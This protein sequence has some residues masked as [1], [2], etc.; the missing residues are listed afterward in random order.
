VQI[1]GETLSITHACSSGEVLHHRTKRKEPAGLPAAL[2]CWPSN[3]RAGSLRAGT[4]P[5]YTLPDNGK[6]V[7]DR[8]HALARNLLREKLRLLVV[9]RRCQ[10]RHVDPAIR[11]RR[12]FDVVELDAAHQRRWPPLR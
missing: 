10:H 3:G 8:R 4:G 7:F 11:E 5:G 6:R 2:G 9:D 12:E 1:A